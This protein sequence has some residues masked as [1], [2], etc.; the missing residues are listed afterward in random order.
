MIKSIFVELGF[1]ADYSTTLNCVQLV[2]HD[3]Q[4]RGY[5]VI[6]FKEIK[7]YDSYLC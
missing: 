2:V 4:Y 7:V 1:Q 5:A 3:I 6:F